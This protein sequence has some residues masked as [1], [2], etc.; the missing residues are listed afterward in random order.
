MPETG[1]RAT[2]LHDV[3][4]RLGAQFT[5][6]AGWDMPVRYSSDLAEHHAV[7]NSAGIFDLS[8]MAEI[9]LIGADAGAALDHA[10]AGK[11]SSISIGR[12]KYTLLLAEDGGVIDDVIV[13]RLAEQRYWVVANAANRD[14]VVT[15]LRERIAGCDVTLTDL[16]EQVTLV[17]VQGPRSQEIVIGA[18]LGDDSGADAAPAAGLT[19]EDIAGLRYYR[20]L[21]GTYRGE[22]LLLARTGY[23]GEDGFE[24]FVPNAL[25]ED[26]WNRLVAVGAEAL[27][28]CGLASR[29][30]LRLEAG[31]PLYGHE[32]SRSILP[33]Q[34]GL[35]GVVALKSKGDFVGRA[36]IEAAARAGSRVKAP[37]GNEIGEITSGAL[38]PTLGHPVALAYVAPQLSGEGTALIADVRGRDLPVTVTALPF[39]KRS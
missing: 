2:A 22:D 4:E 31:M 38:A 34:A 23:T 39:Y 8:H 17:A 32:L 11:L 27:L 5:D 28:P 36:G 6:F 19:D 20:S 15:Q 3:H 26:L 14:V 21:R 30:T 24:L 1:L 10:F 7:R 13:Y 37:D 35:G 16:T 18:L 29:D 12:A 33:A 25:A 9:E